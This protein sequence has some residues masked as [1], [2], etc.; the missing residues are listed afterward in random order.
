MLQK[1]FSDNSQFL[2]SSPNSHR[3]AYFNTHSFKVSALWSISSHGRRMNPFKPVWNLLY[4]NWVSFAG[5]DLAGLSSNFS[6]PRYSIPAS[7]V[8]DTIT[9]RS[10]FSA[11]AMY[12]SKSSYGLIPLEI[13]ST[14]VCSITSLP[15][16]S[17]LKYRLYSQFWSLSIFTIPLSIGWITTTFP[18][19]TPASF[20]FLKK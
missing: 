5:Y 9:R 20:S 14:W 2:N 19:Y 8:L 10:G 3:S 11:N 4:K 7:V 6:V 12:A 17:P 18:S 15:F 16:W 13:T 1:S